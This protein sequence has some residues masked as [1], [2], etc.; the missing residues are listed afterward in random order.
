MLRMRRKNYNKVN[1]LPSVL[2]SSAR[3]TRLPPIAGSQTLAKAIIGLYYTL[4]ST[5]FI[6]LNLIIYGSSRGFEPGCPGP[7]EAALSFCYIEGSGD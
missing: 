6:D 2:A 4:N 5:S 1:A 7:K 3:P